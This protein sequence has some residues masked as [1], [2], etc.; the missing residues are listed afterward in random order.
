MPP[1]PAAYLMI[2]TIDTFLSLW[3]SGVEKKYMKYE[4]VD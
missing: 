2:I 3:L 4:G 1:G